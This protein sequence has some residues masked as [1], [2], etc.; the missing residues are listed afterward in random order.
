MFEVTEKEYCD[1]DIK[2]TNII[3]EKS[4]SSVFSCKQK[5]QDLRKIPDGENKGRKK[6]G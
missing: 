2:D 1:I 4:Q 5:N 6:C 3:V